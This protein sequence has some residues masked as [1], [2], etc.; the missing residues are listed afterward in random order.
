MEV[1]FVQPILKKHAF[2]SIMKAFFD[3]IKESQHSGTCVRLRKGEFS[4][5]DLF[6]AGK[7]TSRVRLSVTL[8][9]TSILASV[10]QELSMKH[11]FS[12]TLWK[13]K[14]RTAGTWVQTIFSVIIIQWVYT[15]D[16]RNSHLYN[17]RD[18]EQDVKVFSKGHLFGNRPH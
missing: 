13:K 3:P 10:V 6:S 1:F 4:G 7:K 2:C 8:T 12:Q 16:P 18:Y 5:G 15:S 9:E 11:V 14:V 17:N